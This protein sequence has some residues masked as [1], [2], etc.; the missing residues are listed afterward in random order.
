M[1]LTLDGFLFLRDLL[2]PETR[3]KSLSITDPSFY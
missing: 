1:V 2:V 3:K